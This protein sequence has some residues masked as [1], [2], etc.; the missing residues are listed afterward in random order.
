MRWLKP[1]GGV[2][3]QGATERG[4]Q[5][6]WPLEGEIQSGG[7]RFF[8]LVYVFLP[9]IDNLGGGEPVK[10]NRFLAWVGK[11]ES[12]RERAVGEEVRP[13]PEWTGWK[14]PIQRWKSR[15]GEPQWRFSVFD[16][17]WSAK[18][19][20]RVSAICAKKLRC[21]RMYLTPFGRV[22]ASGPKFGHDA[23]LAQRWK[24]KR[25]SGSGSLRP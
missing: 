19:Y 22:G 6:G 14:R 20:S 5:W 16:R 12:P 4:F 11:F 7:D 2:D 18:S 10:K 3:R 15:G 8:R 25:V 23:N 9:T 13:R 1:K 24:R 21:V 17:V